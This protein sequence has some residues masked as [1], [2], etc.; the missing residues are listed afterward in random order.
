MSIFA[1]LADDILAFL[2]SAGKFVETFVVTEAQKGVV[3]LKQQPIVT[4]ALNLVSDLENS[5][6]SGPDRLN[7]VIND[8]EGDYAAFVAAGGLAG[9]ELQ[10]VNLLRQF[11]QSV[12][13]D[14]KTTVAGA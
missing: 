8:L 13:D 6:L 1:E 9:L 14:F 11:A 12:F 4:K 10:G 7:K 2:K 5:S 3:L